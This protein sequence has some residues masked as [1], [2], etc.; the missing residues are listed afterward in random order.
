MIR[1]TT[2]EANMAKRT[3][4]VVEF[5]LSSDNLAF[6]SS[7]RE[8]VGIAIGSTYG[9]TR[10]YAK[11]CFEV[12]GPM[13]WAYGPEDKAIPEAAST[14]A[15]KT[16]FYATLKAQGHSNP[17]VIWSRIRKLGEEL[18]NERFGNG[19]A[20][21]EG[22]GEGEGGDSKVADNGKRGPLTRNFDEISKL[23]AHNLK[24][25]PSKTDHATMAKIEAVTVL[26]QSA[27][28]ALA[29]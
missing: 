23:V 1:F 15:E 8:E 10:T 24:L 21:G 16:A 17:S 20:Q 19:E 4:E 2:K 29:D 27:L 7:A 11:A 9:A 14:F 28:A 5:S 26:L 18:Y 12:I 25:D 3:T 22:E 6:L 13:F